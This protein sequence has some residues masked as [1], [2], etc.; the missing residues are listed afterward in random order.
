MCQTLLINL[1]LVWLDMEEAA[2]RHNKVGLLII[3]I[4][5]CKTD[6]KLLLDE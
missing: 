2:K 5:G 3:E 6:A 4:R 1:A